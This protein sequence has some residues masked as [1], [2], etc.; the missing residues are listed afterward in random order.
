MYLVDICAS[1]V[2]IPVPHICHM[3]FADIAGFLT[4]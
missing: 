3:G 4:D 2:Y 1:Y